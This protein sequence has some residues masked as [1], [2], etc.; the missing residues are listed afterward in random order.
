MFYATRAPSFVQRGVPVFADDLAFNIN[1]RAWRIIEVTVNYFA[2]AVHRTLL[3]KSGIPIIIVIVMPARIR[4]RGI[5]FNV[6][7]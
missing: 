5:Y 2:V 7:L 3:E 4:S 6:I 1:L